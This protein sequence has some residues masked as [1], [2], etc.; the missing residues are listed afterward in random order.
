MEEKRY[1]AITNKEVFIKHCDILIQ[2]Y[3]FEH[4]KKEMIRIISCP[5]CK[6]HTKDTAVYSLRCGNCPFNILSGYF[7]CFDH[8]SFEQVLQLNYDFPRHIFWLVAREYAINTMSKK[9]FCKPLS[10]QASNWRWLN[11]LDKIVMSH[12]SNMTNENFLKTGYIYP[13][14]P[15]NSYMERRHNITRY[16]YCQLMGFDSYKQ[17]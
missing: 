11:E 9:R 13:N 1:Y 15:R 16:I 5:L 7:G 4:G 17:S 8:K 14:E 2:K 6:Y 3:V 12:F 10:L